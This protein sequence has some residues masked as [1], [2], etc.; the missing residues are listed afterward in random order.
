MSVTITVGAVSCQELFNLFFEKLTF[1]FSLE[2]FTILSS[3]FF[4]REQKSSLSS[5]QLLTRMTAIKIDHFDRH[6]WDVPASVA[7]SRPFLIVGA[8]DVRLPKELVLTIAGCLPIRRFPYHS[9][10][11]HSSQLHASL[12]QHLQICEMGTCDMPC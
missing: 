11:F 8:D 5:S 6:I 1:C 4:V 9:L 2:P 12:L 3:V 10:L 7:A